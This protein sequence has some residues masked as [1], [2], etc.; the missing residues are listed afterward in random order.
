MSAF[1]RLDHHDGGGQKKFP[2]KTTWDKN[3][4][5]C[6]SKVKFYIHSKTGVMPPDQKIKRWITAGWIS[7]IQPV[8]YDHRCRWVLK[9]EIDK[10]IKEHTE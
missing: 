8:G 10:F 9:S 7:L 1:Q 4:I 2:G 6:L 3:Q 5:I